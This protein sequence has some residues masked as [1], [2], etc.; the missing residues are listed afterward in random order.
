MDSLNISGLLRTAPMRSPCGVVRSPQGVLVYYSNSAFVTYSDGLLPLR[1]TVTTAV[2]SHQHFTLPHGFL[3]TPCGL[4]DSSGLL[5]TPCRLLIN[6][7]KIP[8]VDQESLWT[9]CSLP[10]HSSLT[11]KKRKIP[12]VILPGVNQESLLTPSHSLSTNHKK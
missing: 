9:P 6:C 12:G 10:V 3:W 11:A 8:G 4:P 7:H 2:L 5:R 1:H